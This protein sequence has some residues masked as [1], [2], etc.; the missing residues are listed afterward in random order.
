MARKRNLVLGISIVSV[1]TGLTIAYL[2][3]GSASISQPFATMAA[4]QG[5]FVGIVFSI[6]VLASQVSAAQ[7]TPLTLEQLSRSRGF[8]ALLGFYAFA[9][10]TNVYFIQTQSLPISVPYL[11]TSW[12]LT[13]GLGAGLMTASLLSLLI[14]R[15]LLAELTT[16]EHLLKRTAKSVSREA[17]IK[18]DSGTLSQPAPPK[19]T[20]LFTIERILVE[21][22]KDDDEYTVQQAIHQLWKA[23]DRLLSPPMLFGV[24]FLHSD[25]T[26]YT[27]KLDIE[28]LMDY[29]TTAAYYGTKGPLT[30]VRRTATSHRHLLNKLV[31]ED[32]IP[33]AIDQFEC[34]YELS[35]AAFDRDLDQSVLSEYEALAVE[36][37]DH[38]SSS[39]LTE[40][41]RH[42]ARFVKHQIEQLDAMEDSDSSE[43]TNTLLAAVICNYAMLLEQVWKSD[44]S[45]SSTRNRIDFI[46]SQV[47]ADLSRIFEF[48]DK[49]SNS[50]PR[51]QTLLTELQGQIIDAASSIDTESIQTIDRY[52]VLVAELSIA[53]EREPMT[54]AKSLSTS[55]D[56]HNDRRR[57]LIE[58]FREWSYEDSYQTELEQ[59][60]LKQK[61][62]SGFLEEVAT[63]M[64]AD[65][66]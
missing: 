44:L 17:F 63:V 58:R 27:E 36:V 60:A 16:P 52:I 6:F 21:A 35:I 50:G 54:V 45:S 66:E 51:K 1:F 25:S 18:S 62:A 4:V 34:L 31:K 59:L 15:Q 30:R 43:A 11:P 14:A 38:E 32:E 29:W 41:I 28:K 33:E 9:I 20:S 23:T 65:S 8:A 64:M 56:G 55:L 12:N 22:H 13:L 47:D 26:S 3:R 53:L 42:H 37:A 2:T 61:D 10:L 39:L 7:F 57:V 24:N 40:I 49:E 48:F 19:R 46:I 5:A